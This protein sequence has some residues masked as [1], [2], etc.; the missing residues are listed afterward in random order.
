M[1]LTAFAPLQASSTL[2]RGHAGIALCTKAAQGKAC[3]AR[4][5]TT[6]V[7]TN[8]LGAHAARLLGAA[9]QKPSTI[10]QPLTWDHLHASCRW[11]LKDT[12][13]ENTRSL[14]PKGALPN[15]LARQAAAT[16]CATLWCDTNTLPALQPRNVQ[17]PD[18]LSNSLSST[19]ATTCLCLSAHAHGRPSACDTQVQPPQRHS[20][21]LASA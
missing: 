13:L 14:P 20:C 11:H 2:A 10:A 9:V 6:K 1:T 19:Q 5:S 3:P 12:L 4:H 18:A 16:C 8:P 15:T 7:Q 17:T 21:A